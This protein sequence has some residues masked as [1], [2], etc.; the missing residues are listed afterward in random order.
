M[1]I[2]I[3][4]THKDIIVLQ[5]TIKLSSS[6]RIDEYDKVAYNG[7]S[8]RILVAAAGTEAGE[9]FAF[10][11]RAPV[12]NRSTSCGLLCYMYLSPLLSPSSLVSTMDLYF[13][14]CARSKGGARREK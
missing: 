6:H 11:R 4:T 8:G 13:E 14:E 10:P 7:T 3:N 12:H 2:T 1:N 9:R 5:K